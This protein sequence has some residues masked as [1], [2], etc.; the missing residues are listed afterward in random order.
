MTLPPIIVC[1]DMAFSDLY[2][3]YIID[4][5]SGVASDSLSFAKKKLESR[6]T[7]LG[8][9]C[10]MV[11]DA[12]FLPYDVCI[13]SALNIHGYIGANQELREVATV[14]LD[15]RTIGTLVEMSAEAAAYDIY[16]WGRFS[17]TG[18]QGEYYP[19]Q[20]F[21]TAQSHPSNTVAASFENQFAGE[22]HPSDKIVSNAILGSETLVSE[23]PSR[24]RIIVEASAV[25]ILLP[26]FAINSM[27]EA[28]QECVIDGWDR[29][30]ASLTGWAEGTEGTKGILFLGI[31]R[32]LCSRTASCEVANSDHGQDSKVNK[33]IMLAFKRGKDAIE[34]GLCTEATDDVGAVEKLIL[35]ELVDAT[36]YFTQQV[37]ENP[38]NDDNRANLYGVASAL[39]PLF[40]DANAKEII[41]NNV[42]LNA[43]IF[44]Q[45]MA[46]QV[47][48]TLRTFVS[49]RNIDCT[50]LVSAICDAESLTPQAG[51]DVTSALNIGA[52][53]ESLL[54]YTPSTN[55]DSIIQ[56]TV[57]IEKIQNQ[58]DKEASYKIYDKEDTVSLKHI[59]TNQYFNLSV[60]MTNPL[61]SLYMYA[62][63][64]SDNGGTA[65]GNLEEK[66][67]D[68]DPVDFFSNSIV[69]D[70]YN[71]V[72]GY[73][74]EL[75]G[76]TIRV[77]IMWMA[78][79]QSIYEGIQFCSNMTAA[80]YPNFV[81]PIDKAAAFWI[82]NQNDTPS[83][84]GGSLYAWTRRMQ[85]IFNMPAFDANEQILDDLNL[86]KQDLDLCLKESTS[87][88]E[89]IEIIGRM[90][91]VAKDATT[92][93]TV[94]MVQNF[95]YSLAVESGKASMSGSDQVNNMILYAL[96][97][98]PQVMVCDEA[99]FKKL[100]RLTVTENS[101]FDSSIL[102]ETVMT[103]HKNYVCLE[104]SCEQVGK[105][106][107]MF[108]DWP[109]CEDATRLN[110][111]GYNGVTAQTIDVAK[112]DVD[113]RTIGMLLEM[114][115][116]DAAASVYKYGGVFE[117]SDQ[118]LRS[119]QSLASNPALSRKGSLLQELYSESAD[120][121]ISEAFNEKS[122]MLQGVTAQQRKVLAEASMVAI[123]LHIY[124]IDSLFRAVEI[125]DD[126]GSA[127]V[128]FW[129]KAVAALV[130]WMEGSEEGGSSDNG[131]LFYNIAQYLCTEADTCNTATDSKVSRLLISRLNEG[132]QHLLSKD[133]VYAET[134]A[135]EVEKLL[136]AVLA[137]ITAY[138][139]ES[140][141]EDELDS[142]SL[143]EGYIFAQALAPIIQPVDAGASS[144]IRQNL[145]SF[146]NE[147]PMKDGLSAVLA[148]LNSF[149]TKEGIDC[150]LITTQICQNGDIA[151]PDGVA[152]NNGYLPGTGNWQGNSGNSYAE[153]QNGASRPLL[154]GAYQ[155]SSN[156]DHM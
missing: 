120:E 71:K 70:E 104:I 74:P 38:S 99:G 113:I 133:C 86:L 64:K 123:T 149:V 125:C 145:G 92:A 93:M 54:L 2:N 19:L 66:E 80:N 117:D 1:D 10:S 91:S 31:G 50:L 127:A 44:S 75:T 7:C 15:V 129:D 58:N 78:T 82:G 88:G 41:E 87:D 119:I 65:A 137:D 45:Q 28:I 69:E 118:E 23:A 140:I 89:K 29:A 107:F 121:I 62:L 68:G 131:V 103:L 60:R 134:Q 110:I 109:A 79:A 53:S 8:I 17:K 27:Y 155:P 48:A 146:P 105:A 13:D 84:D 85:V 95:L 43:A 46:N 108:E 153:N 16:R 81:N 30:V 40:N 72:S 100:Y 132:K 150:T 9:N 52:S 39:I 5:K 144:V 25:T 90:W 128:T 122:V 63:W 42:G 36:A 57:D 33:L 51:S 12:S 37:V 106:S 24:R 154:G 98:L 32:Y 138:F 4:V 101:N 21:A 56:L 126:N 151:N 94:P 3:A 135:I 73:D 136:Q 76:E 142:E 49:E 115:S 67:F 20:K 18:L 59:A 147:N 141:V 77:A 124:A 35:T 26:I 83:N 11:G 111:A 96:V 148:A 130:G 61:Y 114:E 152:D 34:S 14:D 143:I 116:Y 55:V 6:Y 156:I 97:T 47:F 112:V 22:T 139:A 102:A